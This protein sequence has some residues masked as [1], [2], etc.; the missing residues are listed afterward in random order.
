MENTVEQESNSTS[1][2]INIQTN[3]DSPTNNNSSENDK[4]SQKKNINELKPFINNYS[5]EYEIK[6][7]LNEKTHG[8]V[9]NNYVLFNKYVFGPLKNLWI[10]IFILVGLSIAYPFYIR[11]MSDFY[12]KIFYYIMHFH[13]VTVQLCLILCYI[14]EPGIIPRNCPDFNKEK[15]E[16]EEEKNEMNKESNKLKSEIK[17]DLN[18]ENEEKKT[19]DMTPRIFT[20]RKCR[21]C[22]IIRPSGA[23]HCSQC[24]NC[25]KGFD[26]HCVIV[27]N[28]IGKRNHK[29]FYLFLVIGLS[30]AI[31]TTSLISYTIIYLFTVKAHETIIPIYKG[32]KWLLFIDIFIFL[33]SIFSRVRM[34]I[35]LFYR[36]L[37]AYLGF[38]LLFILWYIYAPR[39]EKTPS[40]NTPFMLLYFCI[41]ITCGILI[42]GNFVAQTSHIIH[43]ITLKQFKSIHDKIEELPFDRDKQELYN[44]Y[45]RSLTWKEKIN[46]ILKFVFDKTDD[47]LIIPER[48]LIINK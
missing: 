17:D 14:V 35:G 28:C 37:V 39:N 21:T 30:Y 4:L 47:S 22:N 31:I 34:I 25:V 43:N 48:D 11:D 12:P 1:T 9:G 26:H 10:L 36:F 45:F 16:K 8:N 3:K 15:N 6:N 18:K 27:S 29:Y 42:V 20:E 38:L 19:I 33:R 40:Y 5:F 41:A 2:S 23:S 13:F 7:P 44:N 46:N 32:N 24:N